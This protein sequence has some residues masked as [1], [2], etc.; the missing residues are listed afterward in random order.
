MFGN[1]RVG[2]KKKNAIFR[3]GAP[4]WRADATKDIMIEATL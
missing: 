1:S 3:I 4:S 2:Y